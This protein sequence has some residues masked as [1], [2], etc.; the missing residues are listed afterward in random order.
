MTNTIDAFTN[1]AKIISNML[2]G[3]KSPFS[4]HNMNMNMNSNS[5]SNSNMN[6]N[7]NEMNSGQQLLFL[8]ILFVLI[9]FT[10]FIGSLIFNVSIVK[11]F[12]SVKKVSTVDFF[13]L[14]IVLHMLFC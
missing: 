11:I 6:S 9:Y 5:Y 2:A 12:P 13:G 10:M 14:Y 7:I 8:F 1:S 3:S 4:N